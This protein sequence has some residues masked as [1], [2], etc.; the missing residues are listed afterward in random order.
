MTRVPRTIP[1]LVASILLLAFAPL[2]QAQPASSPSP[3]AETPDG[4][5]LHQ[6][7]PSESWPGGSQYDARLD[8]PVHFWRAGL[9]LSEAFDSVA[10]QTGATLRFFPEG[11]ENARVRV[12][13]FLS[14][15]APPTLR[16]VMAQVSW[17]VDCPFFVTDDSEDRA[18]HLMATSIGRGAA[19][20]LHARE[21]R[22]RQEVAQGQRAIEDKLAELEAALELSREQA[23]SRYQGTDDRMLLNLL[24]PARRGAALI[25][26]RR[27]LPWLETVQFTPELDHCG[28]GIS[29]MDLSEEEQ[30]A[31]VAAF[32]VSGTEF[33]NPKV[34]GG[35]LVEA[36][37]VVILANPITSNDA[38]GV[39]P[40]GDYTASRYAVL[41]LRPGAA[42]E[43]EEDI[44]LRRALG[45][46]ISPGQ[47]TAYVER[48]RAE[49]AAEKRTQQS[50]AAA[51]ALSADAAA[52]LADTPLPLDRRESY[53]T[54]RIQ[55]EVA[56]ATGLHVVSDAL[57]DA[58]AYPRT[59]TSGRVTALPS[60]RTFCSRKARLFMRNPEWEWGDAGSFLRFRTANR[61][62]WRAAILPQATLD[63]LADQ[64]APFLPQPEDH[65][66]ALDF[67]LAVDPEQWTRQLA[68]LTDLQIQYGAEV[69]HGDPRDLADAAA[70]AAW[71]AASERAQAG[72]SLIRFLGGLDGG[73]WELARAGSLRWP[74]ELTPDQGELLDQVLVERT[75]H[76]AGP[77]G[78]AHV[79]IAVGEATP[80]E[81]GRMPMTTTLV[82][83]PDGASGTMTGTSSSG[84]PGD[85]TGPQAWHQ[86][87]FTA[88]ARAGGDEE[89]LVFERKSVFLP[90]TLSVHVAVPE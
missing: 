38:G 17:A 47:E 67:T 32:G 31:Y 79:R 18:Y 57:L 56:R 55:E 16:D 4:R 42:L 22:A 70:R 50:T 36:S 26:V 39:V 61:D 77:E 20:A 52:L 9:A 54:W 30:A 15:Q 2:A 11:D 76:A 75:L 71:G 33:E 64:V 68:R 65:P 60:L 85:D 10:E 63:W 48:R 88:L 40:A 21:E 45:E 43:P 13:L 53:P 35:G 51:A 90:T 23:I 83:G 82:P 86:A 81:H 62:V 80:D 24:D 34:S 7:N 72:L 73:Q 37:G 87:T 27:F 19:S 84:G 8:Q 89:T 3:I 1:L 49:L 25:A 14:P 66:T 44:A 28:I 5:P 6:W 29:M 74:E 78:H 59:G 41:D 69:L 58:S 12:H 46:Q